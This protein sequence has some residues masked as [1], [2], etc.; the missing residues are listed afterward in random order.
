MSRLTRA[1]VL[2]VALAAMNLAGATAVAQAHVNDDSASDRYRALGGWSSWLPQTT[3]SP[4]R[5]RT[6][7]TPWSSSAAASMPRRS[8]PPPT[9][10]FRPGWRRSATTA[11]GATPTPPPRRQPS[12]V[13]S[14]TGSSLRSACYPLPW[15]WSRGWPC[16]PPGAQAAGCGP[17]RRPDQ[18]HRCAVRWAATP[19]RQPHRPFLKTGADSSVPGS[20]MSVQV[21]DPFGA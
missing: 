20:V 3:R 15:R 19:T 4:R 2:G 17:A 12:R 16:W 6:R 11:P 14:P 10:P 18:D 13:G 1:L 9:P 21:G 8:R 5:G 7:P